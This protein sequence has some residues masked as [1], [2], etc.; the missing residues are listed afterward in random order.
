MGEGSTIAHTDP[1]PMRDTVYRHLKKCLNQGSIEAGSFL[2]LAAIGRELGMSRTPLRDALLRL[3]AEGFVVIHSRRGVMVKTLDLETIRN[4][5]QILG[6]LEAA[7]LEEVAPRLGLDELA[8]MKAD[9]EAMAEDLGRDDFDAYY[10]HNLEFHDRYL[11][12]GSNGDIDRII[13]IQKERLYDFPRRQDY[14][15]DWELASV[16]EHAR[17]VELLEKGDSREAAAFMRDVHWSFSVQESFIRRYYF[18]RAAGSGS[19]RSVS[20]PGNSSRT[21]AAAKETLP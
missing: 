20:E 1:S 12:L 9:N 8:G 13:R 17:L 14:I 18:E 19:R 15:R 21:S 10:A 11:G 6:A 3:E 16:E 4:L 5:Y 7:V 2:D